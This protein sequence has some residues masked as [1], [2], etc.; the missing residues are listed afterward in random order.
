[1]R[2]LRG[3]FGGCDIERLLSGPGLVHIYEFL[4]D[5]QKL[6]VAPELDEQVRGT[7]RRLEAERHHQEYFA[8]NPGQAYCTVVV[9]P[10]VA[11]FRKHFTER[12][13]RRA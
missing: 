2:Y 13:K 9:A 4:R 12:L 7:L 6:P 11:K 3:R 1:L 5:D 8:R 10:K